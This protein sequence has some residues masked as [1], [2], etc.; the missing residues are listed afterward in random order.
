MYGVG[1]NR[2]NSCVERSWINRSVLA[3]YY[4]SHN[5]AHKDAY[6]NRDYVS[7]KRCSEH[8]PDSV[9]HYEPAK[10]CSD[11]GTIFSPHDDADRA[12]DVADEGTFSVGVHLRAHFC[13]FFSTDK[14][15]DDKCAY[16]ITIKCSFFSTDDVLSSALD[17]CWWI[18]LNLHRFH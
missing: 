3:N 9:T 12:D 1:R 14:Y 15:S 5:G 8:C 16:D 7:T 11:S 2:K 17:A 4:R 6:G 13:S 10:R 18:G